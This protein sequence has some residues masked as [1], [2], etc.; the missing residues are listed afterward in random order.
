MEGSVKNFEHTPK[1]PEQVA[2]QPQSIPSEG[3]INLKEVPGAND[4]EMAQKVVEA[5]AKLD[6]E[7][8]E[9]DMDADAVATADVVELSAGQITEDDLSPIDK[10]D[11]GIIARAMIAVKER[12]QALKNLFRNPDDETKAAMNKVLAKD[13][14]ETIAKDNQ[15]AEDTPTETSAWTGIDA[16]PVAEPMLEQPVSPETFIAH[17][18]ETLPWSDS[19]ATPELKLREVPEDLKLFQEGDTI[20]LNINGEVVPAFIAEVYTNNDGSKEYCLVNQAQSDGVES[21]QEIKNPLMKEGEIMA[22]TSFTA[23]ELEELMVPDEEASQ[24]KGMPA[25]EGTKK[26]EPEKK[27]TVINED[28]SYDGDGTEDGNA[29]KGQGKGEGEK[30]SKESP[31]LEQVLVPEG[32]NISPTE[33][34]R[35]ILEELNS[36][37][38]HELGDLAGQLDAGRINARISP[39]DRTLQLYEIG[40]NKASMAFSSHETQ[41]IISESGLDIIDVLNKLGAS[42][43]NTTPENGA[44][45]ESD[46]VEGNNADREAV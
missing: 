18:D 22:R 44:Q 16:T 42:I 32:E 15:V 1:T 30:T 14:A 2:N 39:L 28:D 10:Q 19:K 20:N 41:R 21:G 23:E 24:T 6:A 35:L 34:N 26:E 11:L 31:T 12:F 8:T 9:G 43:G 40:N 37:H 13:I 46:G 25:S 27:P 5:W 38:R 33:M 7:E 45:T 17:I 36:S 3:D 4:Q 29:N